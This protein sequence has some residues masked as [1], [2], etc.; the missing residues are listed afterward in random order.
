M[1]GGKKK[2]Q[3]QHK[4]KEERG[5]NS[6]IVGAFGRTKESNALQR[7]TAVPANNA[8]RTRT[9]QLVMRRQ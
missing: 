5:D 4:K 2:G 1:E 6:G 9:H 7:G 8:V 3:H